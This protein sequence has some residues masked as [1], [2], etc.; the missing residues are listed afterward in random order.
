MKHTPCFRVDNM[1]CGGIKQSGL[2]RAGMRC[3]IED[4]TE[5]RLLV[6]RS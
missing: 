2:G 1:P 3:A 6:L 5:R 4:M